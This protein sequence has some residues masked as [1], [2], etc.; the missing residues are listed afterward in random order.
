MVLGITRP[1]WESSCDK[2]LWWPLELQEASRNYEWLLRA[3][4]GL[5]LT[6]SNQSGGPGKWTL[7]TIWV[8]LELDSSPAKPPDEDTAWLT[9]RQ[10]PCETLYKG[11][12]WAVPQHLC[13]L[14]LAPPQHR[15][16]PDQGSDLSHSCNLSHSCGN[17]GS[18]THYAGPGIESASHHC[19]D[20]TDLIVP[21]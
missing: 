4:S 12:R 5:Q 11:P 18:L 7:P 14:F 17:A 19:G 6:T 16:V 2:E 8:Y 20:T 13:F 1:N 10:Y 9:L 15:E 3:E 21:R